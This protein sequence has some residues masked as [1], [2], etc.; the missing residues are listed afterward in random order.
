M[1]I[2]EKRNKTL[3]NDNGSR[4]DKRKKR[5]VF[6]LLI[7]NSFQGT[8]MGPFLVQRMILQRNL[9][10][11]QNGP[12]FFKI[13]E[14]LWETYPMEEVTKPRSVGSQEGRR[15]PVLV[16]YREWFKTMRER[17]SV[18]YITSS[19]QMSLPYTPAQV[20]EGGRENLLVYLRHKRHSESRDNDKSPQINTRVVEHR[21]WDKHH[22]SH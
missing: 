2:L 8:I 1:M 9:R 5:K 17:R 12:D 10:M 14:V 11:A 4:D 22:N 19:D 20:N 7:I 16:S 3:N 15:H 21:K 18:S 13:R 6:L